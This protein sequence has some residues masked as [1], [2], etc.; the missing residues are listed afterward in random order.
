MKIEKMKRDIQF[1]SVQDGFEVLAGNVIFTRFIARHS[2]P[3]PIFYPLCT[4]SGINIARRVPEIDGG[5]PVAD[6]PHHRGLWCG[7]GS[8]NGCDFWEEYRADHG[9][10][11]TSSVSY[12]SES[13]MG[14]INLT[15]LWEDA[16]GVKMLQEHRKCL[17]MATDRANIIDLEFEFTPVDGAVVFGDTKEGGLAAVRLAPMMI[18]EKTGHIFNANGDSYSAGS[19]GN[20]ATWGKRSRWCAYA[21]YPAEQQPATVAMIQKPGGFRFPTWWHVRAYGLFAANP[22]GLS[23][24]ESGT[25]PPPNGNFTLEPGNVL[26][27]AYRIIV[28]D[29]LLTAHDISS[30][31]DVIG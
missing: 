21:G 1:E 20:E 12:K 11:R 17:I 19:P 15:A 10:I 30:L 4:P 23:Y 18:A 29:G 31:I 13:N 6:H 25:T 14:H 7:H 16:Q 24:F 8:V 27:T 2:L 22:F 3:K 26:K 9:N 5:D 28:A